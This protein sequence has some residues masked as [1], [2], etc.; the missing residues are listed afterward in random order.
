MRRVFRGIRMFK[1]MRA[2]FE[3]LKN[4]TPAIEYREVMV[5]HYEG[6]Y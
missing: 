4:E 3:H 2:Q 5:G 1:S 6:G